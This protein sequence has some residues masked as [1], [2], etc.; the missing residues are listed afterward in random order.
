MSKT[1][2]KPRKSQP[3]TAFTGRMINNPMTRPARR[4]GLNAAASWIQGV[5]PEAISS[6]APLDSGSQPSWT[7]WATMGPFANQTVSMP[8]TKPKNHHGNASRLNSWPW[9]PSSVLKII[10]ARD[11]VIVSAL[12]AEMIVET[13]IVTANWR[14][15]CP[16]IPP[17]KQQGM[18]TALSTSVIARTGPVISSIALI[19]AVRESRPVAISRSMFSRTTMA[20]STTIPIAS[21]RPKSVRLFRLKPMAAMIANVPI[22]E[23]GTSI[24]GRII[25]FQSWRKTSTTIPTRITASRR[26]LKT[27]LTDSWMNG[28]VS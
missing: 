2:L 14:K 21:T 20:S 24:I 25:A 28:V 10:T 7:N 1:R 17:R 5:H 13:A 6:S 11:G 26:V 3:S 19:V 27:S 8:P 18:K 9:A 16:V 22:K 23:T 12:I 15:N 4:P